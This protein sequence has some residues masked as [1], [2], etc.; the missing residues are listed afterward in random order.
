MGLFFSV[1]FLSD[2]ELRNEG[3]T[4]GLSIFI[5]ETKPEESVDSQLMLERP[6]RAFLVASGRLSF[7]NLL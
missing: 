2:I 7:V 1:V 5:S 4:T 6:D 3:K